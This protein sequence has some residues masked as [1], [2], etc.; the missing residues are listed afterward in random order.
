MQQ[1]PFPRKAS[2]LGTLAHDSS[3]SPHPP[4]VANRTVSHSVATSLD[5]PD[6]GHQGRTRQN[7]SFCT[8][9][10]EDGPKMGFVTHTLRLAHERARGFLEKVIHNPATHLT[11]RPTYIVCRGGTPVT[12]LI[13]RLNRR[14]TTSPNVSSAIARL[15]SFSFGYRVA[16]HLI[17]VL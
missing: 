14:T 17:G 7:A 1:I 2:T 16:V 4:P 12:F 3:N 6:F 10:S 8:H 11:S 5:H 9:P 13:L 15:I